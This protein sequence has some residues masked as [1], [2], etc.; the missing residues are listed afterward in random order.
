LNPGIY[1]LNA[2]IVGDVNESE[3]Y[4][5]RFIDVAMFRVI[6]DSKGFS[7]GI[8]DFGCYPEFELQS[9]AGLKKRDHNGYETQ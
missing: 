2:G 8:V 6:P 4:L 5:H 1:F 7:S 9:C 3:G